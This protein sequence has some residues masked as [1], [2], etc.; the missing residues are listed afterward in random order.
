MHASL[1]D[2]FTNVVRRYPSVI[3]DRRFRQSRTKRALRTIS[4]SFAP[5]TRV[6][7]FHPLLL[8]VPAA[9]GSRALVPRTVPRCALSRRGTMYWYV[10]HGHVCHQHVFIAMYF[11]RAY[12]RVQLLG[13]NVHEERSS[14]REAIKT[15]AA[16]KE[17]AWSVERE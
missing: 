10:L 7:H 8:V 12:T 9:I 16:R 6:S 4:L 5:D 13:A 1:E 2:E 14:G 11:D 15:R 17:R 3:T